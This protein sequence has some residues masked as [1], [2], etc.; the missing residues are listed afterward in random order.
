MR[1]AFSLIELLL[2]VF[3]LAIGIISI[4]ALFPAGIAQQQIA[5]D[6]Q[7]GPV[8]ADHALNVVRSKVGP[9]DFGSFEQ[10]G[11]FDIN[12][13]SAGG[14]WRSSPGDW[15]WMRPSILTQNIGGGLD[16]TGAVDIFSNY[17]E[18]NGGGAAIS[19]EEF[20]AGGV[21][22]GSGG[23]IY[24]IPYNAARYAQ[25]PPVMIT[26]KERY[27][28][29]AADGLAQTD[30]PQYCWDVM[31]R[32][33]GGKMQVAVF[34]YRVLAP[35]G[36][37]R[38][39]VAVDDVDNSGLPPVPY[40]RMTAAASQTTG[41]ASSVPAAWQQPA[42]PLPPPA[43]MTIPPAGPYTT[44]ALGTGFVAAGDFPSSS[45][46]P[47]HQWQL[48]GQWLLE[49]NGNVLRVSQGRRVSNAD[50]AMVRLSAPIPRVPN[51]QVYGDY[52]DP[53]VPSG[54][55]AL[56]YVPAIDSQGNQ[57]VPVYATVRDL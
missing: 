55:R 13:Q 24:G 39:Y 53:S 6:D 9:T 16:E 37:A 2:A 4:A 46:F 43:P 19:L 21:T 3:I 5:A 23:K 51:A 45:A 47:W 44:G 26:A 35:G 33:F 56:W 20:P 41:G 34:V 7:M 54:I 32:R 25:S 57:L 12:T 15:S 49:N 42:P 31:F 8:V 40:R 29:M 50:A 10:F 28:P 30:P 18:L 17:A 36:G 38:A 22:T 48:P 52:E 11:I 14:V 27:W 1:R